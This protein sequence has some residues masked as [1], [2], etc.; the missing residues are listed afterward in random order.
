MSKRPHTNVIIM[1]GARGTGKT[2][3]AQKIVEKT[4]LPKQLAIDTYYHPRYK[5]D[6]NWPELPLN[7]L[8]GNKWHTGKFHLHG[9]QTEK[10][11]QIVD[12]YVWNTLVIFEDAGKFVDD[13]PSKQV[14]SVCLDSKNKGNEVIFMYHS[15]AEV[16]KKFFRWADY[17]ILFK[18][19]EVIEDQKNRISCYN[20]ILPAF[21]EVQKAKHKNERI[22]FYK[23]IRIAG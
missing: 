4:K 8:P 12:L 6:F 9:K 13:N 10:I 19:Q 16:P 1:V 11:V 3:L 14:K 5:D 18:T 17:L 23:T 20:R 15:L 2:S 7:Y 22:Q 21:N